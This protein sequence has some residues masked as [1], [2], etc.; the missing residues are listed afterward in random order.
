MADSLMLATGTGLWRPLFESPKELGF[1]GACG[2]RWLPKV[3]ALSAPTNRDRLQGKRGGGSPRN[4][5]S[6]MP[7][8]RCRMSCSALRNAS[9]DRSPNSCRGPIQ[10]KLIR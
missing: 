8:R 2:V 10:E 7:P 5:F 4:S 9:T 6:L 1:S 3:A